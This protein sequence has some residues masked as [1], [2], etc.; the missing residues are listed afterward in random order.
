MLKKAHTK[1]AA[2]FLKTR[3]SKA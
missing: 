1:A 3:Q 2:T